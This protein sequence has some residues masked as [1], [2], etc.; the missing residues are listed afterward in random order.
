MKEIVRT[1]IIGGLLTV[2]NTC[3]NQKIETAQ[4]SQE[5][6]ANEKSTSTNNSS[7]THYVRYADSVGS[8]FGILENETIHQLSGPPFKSSVKTGTIVK[9]SEVKLLAP[10][11]PGKVIAIGFNYQ[12]HLDGRE[13]DPH[14]G[15]FSKFPT[16]IIGP[17]S[18]IV[19]PPGATNVHFEGEL[20][21]VIGKQAHQVSQADV[22]EYIFGVTAGNDVSERN[23]QQA[24]LQWF[25]AKGSDTFG[26]IGPAIVSGLN[27]NNLLLQTRLNGNIV[28]E[29]RTDDLIF[30]IQ[31]I[32]SYVSD[33]V[34]LDPGDII[35]TGTPGATSPMK[36]GD[37]IEVEIE[38]VGVLTNR[39]SEQK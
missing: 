12:S 3:N 16:S 22:D 29:Q 32:V 25:R 35:F 39:I 38:G 24:D 26:P 4:P 6:I 7:V 18:E 34:T 15:V 33:F 8:H 5:E 30:N 28:Q 23:W 19:F 10:V 21:V 1:L 17:N 11:K 9:R 14:P 37:L 20:V 13:P 2:T 36:A 31:K 27:Y